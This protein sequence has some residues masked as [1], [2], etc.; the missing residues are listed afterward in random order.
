MAAIS[1]AKG[2][3]YPA[4]ARDARRKAPTMKQLGKRF[5]EDYVPDH[6]KPST[7]YEY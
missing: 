7:L 3:G 5:L 2:G 4:A 6:C 1:E